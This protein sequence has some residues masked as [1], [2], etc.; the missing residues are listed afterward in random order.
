MNGK[1]FAAIAG[2]SPALPHS[3]MELKL[4]RQYYPFAFGLW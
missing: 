2:K 4:E 3:N 1:R